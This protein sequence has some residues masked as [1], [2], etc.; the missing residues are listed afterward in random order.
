M[1]ET[2][3]KLCG[4][5]ATSG[6]EKNVRDYII[7]RIDGFCDYRTD[8]L[9]NIIAF[10][11][12]KNRSAKKL[13]VDAHTDEV[14]LIITHIDSDGFLRFST[15]GGIETAV[16]MN[17]RVMI[18]SKT[19]GVIGSRPIHLVKGEA[20][21]KL[22][23]AD[24]L[25]ID[26]GAKSEEEARRSVR[27]GDRAVM[28]GEYQD[29]GDY[30][31]S[32]A[33]DDRIGCAVLISLLTQES[34]YDFYATFTVQE[35]VGARGAKTAA[36]ALEPDAAVILE[37]TTA[38]D[39]ADVA[40]NKSVCSLGKGAAISF[41]DKGTVYDKELFD[42]ALNSGIPCQVKRAVAGGNN[43]GT[44]HLNKSGVRTIAVSVPCRYIHSASGVAHI[45]DIESAY[46]LAKY[47][48]NSICGG[49]AG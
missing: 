24:S 48:I 23:E 30:I 43:S 8:A 40:E 28:C 35:E 17:R 15:V 22:P 42:A 38:A 36:F 5:D 6:D 33:L 26:I 37:G 31:L 11:K 41:M 39:I 10:K 14:G 3:K 34:D 19:A 44:V 13:M 1:L 49:T 9:G 16:M 46:N 27:E 7:G 21:K 45:K 2:L 12:G 29:L 25:Y 47:L 20:G 32:K 4:L 18:G